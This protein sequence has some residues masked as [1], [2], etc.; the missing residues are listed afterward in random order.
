MILKRLKVLLDSEFRQE[1]VR[2]RKEKSYAD[3]IKQTIAFPSPKELAL[4][5]GII[6]YN[7]QSS[8]LHENQ[9]DTDHSDDM[10]TRQSPTNH[11][12]Q[13]MICS[14]Q[15]PALCFPC[16][17]PQNCTTP[18]DEM[19]INLWEM[20]CRVGPRP[21]IFVY[22]FSY[23]IPQ[24]LFDKATVRLNWPEYFKVSYC[25]ITRASHSFTADIHPPYGKVE[26]SK[27]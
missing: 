20:V 25:I 12:I 24:E 22:R 17:I 11:Q 2:F 5:C 4:A 13:E 19:S 27:K 14:E 1:Q 3:Q 15:L 6:S 8:E 9:S 21:V 10:D 26:I 23:G 16:L 18:M 7:D